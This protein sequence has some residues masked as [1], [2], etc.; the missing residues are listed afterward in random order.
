MG[1][2]AEL[3]MAV[4]PDV[5]FMSSTTAGDADDLQRRTGIPVVALEYGDLGAKRPIFYASLRGIG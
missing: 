1:G 2:D 5:I 3:I 4:Q